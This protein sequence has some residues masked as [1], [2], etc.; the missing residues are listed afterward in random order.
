MA[1][2]G[3]FAD[4]HGLTGCEPNLTNNQHFVTRTEEH[5]PCGIPVGHVLSIHSSSPSVVMVLFGL[6][7]GQCRN[8]SHGK[9]V[10]KTDE[11]MKVLVLV[12]TGSTV[13]D[14]SNDCAILLLVFQHGQLCAWPIQGLGVATCRMAELLGELFL[15]ICH[16]DRGNAVR[17]N[18]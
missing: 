15:A 4:T 10:S 17:R 3:L 8:I 11:D 5:N 14:W 13:N 1:T 2:P 9:G 7:R 6:A 18:L 16:A 12:N